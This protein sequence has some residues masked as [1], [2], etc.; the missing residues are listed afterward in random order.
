M[1]TSLAQAVSFPNQLLIQQQDELNRFLA[2]LGVSAS[3]ALEDIEGKAFEKDD[4]E[5]LKPLYKNPVGDEF[6]QAISAGSTPPLKKVGKDSFKEAYQGIAEAGKEADKQIAKL[7]SLQ[8]RMQGA[9]SKCMAKD[10]EKLLALNQEKEEK[11]QKETGERNERALDSMDR[12]AS[13]IAS[14]GYVAGWCDESRRGRLSDLLSS[15]QSISGVDSSGV[16]EQLESGMSACI[17]SGSGKAGEDAV[18]QCQ[19][20]VDTSIARIRSK[21]SQIG[22]SSGTSRSSSAY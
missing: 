6:I 17:H 2:G 8:E 20:K 18:A 14:C 5:D 1:R 16:E 13:D 21:I 15:I 12:A 11:E 10:A 22:R 7:S 19:A 9:L 3:V 4:D